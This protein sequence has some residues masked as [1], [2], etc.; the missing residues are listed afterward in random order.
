MIAHNLNNNL[1][2]EGL[3][4]SKVNMDRLKNRMHITAGMKNEGTTCYINALLQTLFIIAPLRKAVFSM[5][6][7]EHNT[8]PLCLQRIFNNLQFSDEPIRTID[9]LRSFGWQTHEANTQHDV[10]E[11][12]LI[13]SATLEK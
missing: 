8:I 2:I 11:F 10:T 6:S 13:L 5:Q 7:D 1:F 3:I 4:E 9:L 12:N